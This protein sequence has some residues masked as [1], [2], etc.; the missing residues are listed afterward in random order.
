MASGAAINTEWLA[1][2]GTSGAW[3][4]P[5]GLETVTRGVV[6]QEFQNHRGYW[7]S[8]VG[9][10]WLSDEVAAEAESLGADVAGL[11][12]GPR[13]DVTVNGGGWYQPFENG[14]LVHSTAGGSSTFL[15]AGAAILT[16]YMAAGGPAGAWGWPAGDEVAGAGYAT[17]AFEG[18]TAVWRSRRGVTT[19]ANELMTHIESIG[20]FGATGLPTSAAASGAAGIS[21]RCSTIWLRA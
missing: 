13:V 10:Y 2:G 17:Q 18:V 1:T 15:A 11:P 21:Q 12:I 3:G 4:W 19:V 14:T 5:I 6:V 8:G 7:R 9:V 16:S 20:G